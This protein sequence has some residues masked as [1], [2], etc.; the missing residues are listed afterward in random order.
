MLAT[1]EGAGRRR[2]A[3][4]AQPAA[5]LLWFFLFPFF[6]RPFYTAFFCEVGCG[7]GGCILMLPLDGPVERKVA[8]ACLPRTVF[9]FE[10][11]KAATLAECCK[12]RENL[13]DVFRLP[14]SQQA[15]NQL[16]LLE[17]GLRQIT[18]NEN[19]DYRSFFHLELR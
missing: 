5:A 6:T 17:N 3:P 4:L 12:A 15:F 19:T 13:L 10:K 7:V 16:A 1:G 2:P 18:L 14:L 9:S 8:N 11:S